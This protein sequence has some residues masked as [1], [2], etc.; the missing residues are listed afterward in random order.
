[1]EKHKDKNSSPAPYDAN[2]QN[3]K[4]VCDQWEAELHLTQSPGGK[5]VPRT[6]FTAIDVYS[7]EKRS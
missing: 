3:T 6:G 2:S 5:R 7:N 4:S 1:M